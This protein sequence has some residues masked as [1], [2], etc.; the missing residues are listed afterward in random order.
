MA[1]EP[2]ALED[3]MQS[4]EQKVELENV[5]RLRQ[6]LLPIIERLEDDPALRFLILKHGKPQAVLMSFPTYQLLQKLLSEAVEKSEAMGR[7]ERIANSLNEWRSGRG[8]R[9]SQP[10][11]MDE[12][13]P[14]V[15]HQVEQAM[16][17]LKKLSKQ[18][19]QNTAVRTVE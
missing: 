6:N 1:Q 13:Q 7:E 19:R 12:P 9:R 4:L 3:M 5:T 2:E 8:S 14:Q 17:I 18:L 11:A 15:A 10:V 16:T